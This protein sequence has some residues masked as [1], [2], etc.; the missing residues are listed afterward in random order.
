MPYASVDDIDIR[1]EVRGRGAPLL[2]LPG[3]GAAGDMWGDPFL[4]ALAGHL[5]L[6]VPDHR[7]V[8][9][10]RRGGG[11]Y[12]VARLAAD[13]V[14]VLDA[15]GVLAAH[16]FGVSLGGMVALQM[17]V[18]RPSRVRTLVLGGATAGGPEAA[19]PRRSLMEDLPREGLLG[20]R[21][22]AQ[23]VTP[24]F[25]A[26]RTGLL[27]RL[28]VR[29]L[30]RPVSPAL[31][32]EQLVAVSGCDLSDRLGE[33]LAP[34]LVMTGDRDSVFPASNAR[35]LVRGIRDARGALVKDAAHCFW[36]EAPERA[37]AAVVEFCT[38]AT[39]S[40]ALMTVGGG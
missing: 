15:E 17:A 40:T 11:S 28:A 18:D 8:G 13:A 38:A 22:A 39:P 10:T 20:R 30:A 23:L 27:T 5:R 7:G 36:W 37:A 1:Y 24:E 29:A 4:D 12:T 16:V 2:L 14:A 3:I 35:A 31:L 6:I 25:T 26:R 34:T 32:R 19:L 33:A 9:G 21:V